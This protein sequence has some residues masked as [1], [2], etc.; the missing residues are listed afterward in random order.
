[1]HLLDRLR[2]AIGHRHKRPGDEAL[3]RVAHGAD[4][5]VLLGE[6]LQQAVLGVVGVLVLVDEDVAERL[7]PAL[8]G[9][10][11]PLQHLHG[12]HQQVVEVD[13]VRGEEAP[14][15]EVVHLRDGLVVERRDPA[16]VLIRADQLVLR[17]RDLRVDAARDEALRVA[18]ELFQAGL[19]QPHLVGLV[20]DREVRAVAEARRF[21]AQDPAAGGVEGEDPDRVRQRP[22]QVFEPLP[23]LRRGLVRER[24]R[25]DLVRLHAAGVD[26][27]RDTVGEHA[28][29]PGARPGDDEK[30]PLGGE[31]RFPLCRI[32]VGEVLL[33]RRN[34]HPAMLAAP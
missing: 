32:Q 29:L 19:G 14:L 22:E 28:R 15:V 23:H 33:G 11:E 31:D 3:V 21:A 7:L 16:Q 20:V 26:Q 13:G 6:E 17:V 8:A 10:G 18:L 25:E 30:R 5:A 12:E 4:V 9:L 27:M 2:R 1:V 34:G 24:D